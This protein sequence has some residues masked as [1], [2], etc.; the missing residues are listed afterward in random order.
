MQQATVPQIVLNILQE[1]LEQSE[2]ELAKLK[3]KQ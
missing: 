2:L 1:N 3:Q